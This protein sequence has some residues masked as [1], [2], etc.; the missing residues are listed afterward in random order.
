MLLTIKPYLHLNL[1]AYAKLIYWN[2]TVFDIE[3]CI[4]TKQNYLT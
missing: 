4:N 2:R 3:N 1:H